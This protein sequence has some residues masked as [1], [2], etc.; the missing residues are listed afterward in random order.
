MTF[1]QLVVLLGTAIIAAGCATGAAETRAPEPPSSSATSAG[2]AT[3][4][5]DEC[6]A[7]DD[8]DLSVRRR[9]AEQLRHQVR[10]LGLGGTEQQM[11]AAAEWCEAE[12]GLRPR[13]MP[14]RTP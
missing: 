12:H 2:T 6:L 4:A 5:R 14:S 9:A 11:E 1:G 8:D 3:A 7:L 13:W 10:S